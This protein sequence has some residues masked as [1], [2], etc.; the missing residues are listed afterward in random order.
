MVEFNVGSIS[1]LH[2][3]DFQLLWSSSHDLVYELAQV[4]NAL[5]VSTVH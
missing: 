3:K 5:C 1:P 4:A 2:L